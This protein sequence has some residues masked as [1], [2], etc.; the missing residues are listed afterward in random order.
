MR[1]AE[2]K[3]N[4]TFYCKPNVKLTLAP[5]TYLCV[6]GVTSV[7]WMAAVCLDLLENGRG[8]LKGQPYQIANSLTISTFIYIP[9]GEGNEI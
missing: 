3:Q 1:A 5:F 4:G 6:S 9:T 7:F 8:C 2:Y